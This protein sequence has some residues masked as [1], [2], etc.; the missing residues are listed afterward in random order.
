MEGITLS[1]LEEAFEAEEWSPEYRDAGNP[2]EFHSI[3]LS[4]EDEKYPEGIR[5]VYVEMAETDNNGRLI[6][7]RVC[8]FEDG[9]L[10][11]VWD[12][13]EVAYSEK[14]VEEVTDFILSN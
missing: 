1:A 5:H 6:L 8:E 10:G 9:E 12:V 13:E 3:K 7:L 11:D 14:V 4:I 2:L